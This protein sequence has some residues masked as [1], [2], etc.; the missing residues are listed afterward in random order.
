MAILLNSSG[1]YLSRTASLPTLATFTIAA[2][3]RLDDLSDHRGVFVRGDVDAA[4]DAIDVFYSNFGGELAFAIANDSGSD[5]TGTTPIA[6]RWY[7]VGY[8]QAA[9]VGKFYLNAVLDISASISVA[10]ISADL[11]LVGK[12]GSVVNNARFAYLRVWDNV[13]LSAS[14]LAAEMVSATAVRTS[15]L[16]SDAP[17]AS[18]GDDVSGAARHWTV[19]GSPSYGTQPVLS[20][21]VYTSMP[22]VRPTGVAALPLILRNPQNNTAKVDYLKDGPSSMLKLGPTD[23]RAIFEALTDQRGA[24]TNS[25]LMATSPDGYTWTKGTT[26]PILDA[27]AGNWEAGEICPDSWFW[28]PDAGAYW[29]YYHGGNNAG[30]RQIGLMT[31]TTGLPGSWVR[32]N[33]GNPILANGGS[34][35]I[36]ENGVADGWVVRRSASDYRMIY[37]TFDAGNVSRLA[38]ATSTDGISWSKYGSNP[39]LDL[40][41]GNDAQNVFGGWAYE[42]ALGRVHLWYCGKDGSSV[43]RVLYAYSE[44]WTTWARDAT[45]IILNTN[46]GGAA[47]DPDVEIGDVIRGFHDDGLLFFTL[48]NFNFSA[49]TGDALGRLEGRGLYW[50]PKQATSTPTRPA[51]ASRVTFDATR[52]YLDVPTAAGVLLNSS[53]WCIYAEFRCP[54]GAAFRSFY[55]ELADSNKQ[56]QL[57]LATDGTFGNGTG[58]PATWYR[59]PTLN[60]NFA[61]TRRYDDNRMHWVLFRRTGASAFD[62]IVDGETIASNT[63]S[64]GTDATA[65]AYVNACGINPGDTTNWTLTGPGGGT[66]GYGGLVLRRLVTINSYAMTVDEGR[67]LW[68]SGQAGGSLPG[69]GTLVLDVRPGNGGAAGPD[70]DQSGNAYSLTVSGPAMIDP[71]PAVDSGALAGPTLSGPRLTVPHTRPA[72]FRPGLAR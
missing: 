69:S 18:D 36:D 42:D 48:M 14:E 33:S 11:L 54:P 56:V 61:S 57:G 19:N 53:T 59:T 44:D 49:Y 15:G 8:T 23:Y 7:H 9:G 66:T 10:G 43:Q 40:G 25:F 72:A 34:G 20:G 22:F 21:I 12:F 30:P 60:V 71:T 35:A 64:P 17:L 68:N 32:A 41:S 70:T 45:D 65:I 67:T 3:V 26:Q 5:T 47:G 13:A 38:Y 37:K 55:I 27:V 46:P 28:N 31:S 62:V 4:S 1:Q 39:I 52:Q 2:W 50:L 6:N 58:R 24:L 51:R 29:L 63:G 16:Y